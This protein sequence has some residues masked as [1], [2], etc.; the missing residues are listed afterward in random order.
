MALQPAPRAC[1]GAGPCPGQV[2][3][4]A[5]ADA[6]GTTGRGWWHLVWVQER[7]H[8][9]ENEQRCR[10]LRGALQELGASMICFK[11][12][13]KFVC[14]LQR[15]PRPFFVLVTDWREAQP[16]VQFL[17]QQSSATRPDCTVVI[18]DSA[19]QMSRASEW[20]RT[21]PDS[22]S[23]VYVCEHSSIPTTL[24]DGLI[25]R[26]FSQDTHG[27]IGE[28][29]G[30]EDGGSRKGEGAPDRASPRHGCGTLLPPTEVEGGVWGSSAVPWLEEAEPPRNPRV[31]GLQPAQADAE[32]QVSPPPSSLQ[33]DTAPVKLSRT[34]NGCLTI[35]SI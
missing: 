29:P 35:V 25:W 10:A 31:G 24:L 27:S 4:A 26:H 1:A 6:R 12:A 21:V 13:N 7:C 14:W 30:L 3:S 20:A 16:C 15:A 28:P 33:Q 19:R 2:P 22:V 11:K 17:A 23:P 32:S 18:C 8:K 5:E 34:G 9:S